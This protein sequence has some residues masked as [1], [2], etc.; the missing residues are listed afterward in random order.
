MKKILSLVLVAV[1]ALTMLTACSSKEDNAVTIASAADLAGKKIAVQE[2]TTGDALVTETVDG[3]EISRFKKV[4]DAGLDLKAGKV[5]AV[6]VDDLV[7]KKLVGNIEGLKILDEALSVE[8]YAIAVKKGNT[9]LLEKINA[10]LKEINENGKYDSFV[11]AFVV[12]KEEQVALEARDESTATEE[13]VM[14]TNAEFEPFEYRENDKIV[15]F[16]IEIANEIADAMGK[17]LVIEDMAFDSLITALSAGKVDF[18]I[19]GMTAT[20]ERRQNVDFSDCYFNASQVIIIRD[21]D[22]K[23]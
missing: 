15:G 10:T 12:D 2:G 8:E 23:G 14:G 3:A 18:V 16:D 20:E 17:K 6:V 21:P 4:V 11:N 13:I 9:E 1:L 7:A 5:D 19:A 22:F